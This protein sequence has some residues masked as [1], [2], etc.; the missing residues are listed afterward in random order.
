[1]ATRDLLI[2]QS[3]PVNLD[4]ER[5]VLGAIMTDEA[6]FLQVGGKLTEDDFSLEKH[7]RIFLRMGELQERGETN[8]PRNARERADEAR[9]AAIGRRPQLPGFAR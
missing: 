5:F 8:R 1:M 6:A 2:E 4:A 9:R 3:L 7:K